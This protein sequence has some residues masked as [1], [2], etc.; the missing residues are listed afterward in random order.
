MDKTVLIVEDCRPQ[1]AMLEKLVLEV[2]PETKVYPVDNIDAAYAVMLKKTIDVFIIDIILDTTK[3]GDT[4][5]IELAKRIR[6][7]EKYLLA[8]IIFVTSMEDTTKYAYTNLNCLGY[9]EKPFSP[10]R[11]KELVEKALHHT[12]DKRGN[13]SICFGKD[14]ILYP[15]KIDEILY[16]ESVKQTVYVHKKDGQILTFPYLTCQKILDR[17]DTDCLFQCARGVI[18]NKDYVV[19]IDISNKYITLE[20]VVEKIEIGVSFKKKVLEEFLG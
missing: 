5:G 13:A 10:D 16:I 17:A 6:E 4:S 15:V 8:P 19:N 11:V 1:L 12:T 18:I 9:V 20:G 3:P 2:K 7:I 14:R